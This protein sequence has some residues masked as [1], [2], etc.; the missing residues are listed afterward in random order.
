M[1]SKLN[2]GP[3]MVGAFFLVG[4]IAIF[5]GIVGYNSLG[6]LDA[7]IT[8]IGKVRLVGVKAL[9]AVNEG[10]TYLAVGNLALLNNKIWENSENRKGYF[11]KVDEAQRRISEGRK[12]FETLSHTS[13][14]DLL[15]KEFVT[16]CDQML[17]E[18]ER[19]IGLLEEKQRVEESGAATGGDQLVA[20]DKRVLAQYME[21]YRPLYYEAE[22]ALVKVIELNEKLSLEEV[23][24]A[25]KVAARSNTLMLTAMTVGFILAIFLGAFMSRSITVPL[26]K[27]VTMIQELGKGHLQMRL[28]MNRG[29][30]IGVMA[31]TMD[32]FADDLQNNVVGSMQRIAVGDVNIQLKPKDAQD[33]ITPAL[34][35]TV[36][37]IHGLVDEAT[38]LTGAAVDGKLATRGDV[39]RFKGSYREILQGINDTLNAVIGPLNVAGEYVDRISK[40]DIPQ[41]ITDGYRGD[42][43]EI[44]N[45]LNICIDA[46][47]QLVADSNQLALAMVEGKLTTRADA[48]RHQGD[49]RKIVAGFNGGMDRLV[50]LIDVMPTPAMI[51]DTD[52]TVRYMNE[53]GAKV[54][55]KIPAQVIGTKCFDH[56]RTSDCRTEKCSVGRA[57]R[58]GREASSETDAH[59][60]TLDLDIAYSGVPLRDV[61]GKVI[62]CFEM[63][64]ADLTAV[65]KA[66]RVAKK[67]STYQENETSKVVGWLGKLARG[68]MDFTCSTETADVDT[69]EA[70]QIFDAITKTINT[71]IEAIK[72]VVADA[73]MLSKAAVEGKLANRADASRH[74]GDFRKIVQGVNDT[75]DAIIGPINEASEVLKKMAACE[76]ASRM[77]GEY[78]GDHAIIKNNLNEGMEAIQRVFRDVSDIV[79]KFA[80]GDLTVKA[81]EAEYR[82]DVVQLARNLN[83]SI[84]ALKNVIVRIRQTSISVAS[85]ADQISTNTDQITKGAQSQASAADETS[86]S[87]EEMSVSIQGVARIAEGLA[88]NVDETTSSIQQMGTTAGGV[89]RNAE[90][91]ASNVSETSSTIEQMV[92]TLEKTAKN[93]DQAD[94][95]SQQAS[96]EAEGGGEAVLKTVNGMRNISD[97]ME[98]ISAVIQNLGQRSEAI[99]NIVE[100]IEEIADQTN[101]LALNAAIEAARAGDAGR[102]F[103]VV[104]DEVRKL[105]ERSIKATKEI[106]EVIKQVQKD[107]ASAVTATEGGAKV[108]REGIALADQA[109]AAIKRIMEAVRSSSDIMRDIAMATNEQSIAAKN[110]IR[111]VEEMNKLTQAVTQ[112]TREQAS[113]VGQVVKASEDMAQLTE[114]V[115]NATAEQKRGGENVVKAVENIRD[116]AKSN[117]V[118]VEQL[119]SSAKGLA[120]QSEGLQELVQA[121]RV[122]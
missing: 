100:V 4:L 93:V 96:T 89:S 39:S 86:A 51:V 9:D 77:R 87:M 43:N 65:K 21:R 35:A 27:T 47:N 122:S 62:G 85:A 66:Q 25:D 92:V 91:M 71:S 16:K 34:K 81:A 119:A 108:S 37:A 1:L 42:F 22:Q 55:G 45:N 118:S 33:E 56:F 18:E 72:A 70:K 117:L 24:L 95:L 63:V 57:L 48:T 53:V 19:Y 97:T 41:K 79:G 36:E 84:E 2:L 26:A 50:G 44:K 17:R 80:A 20:M 5:V 75:L 10:K 13:E 23:Q 116:I 29:D 90:T 46:V 101:L 3:K 73:N 68:E 82:G 102:G 104:A 6:T 11:A 31:R 32:L 60:G 14:E 109:G 74:Q 112:S 58:D 110:V 40:G 107:T 38:M 76:F 67:V 120:R 52:F 30:E 88:S 99:G 8:D 59:P 94:K 98:N 103:A 111:A 121:F 7:H 61:G 115:K 54:G 83:A 78:R 106:G 15:W 28:N 69:Q 49:F 64:T 114:K 113:G 12:T 105:A